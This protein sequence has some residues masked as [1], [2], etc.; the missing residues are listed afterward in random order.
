MTDPMI[1]PKTDHQP[2]QFSFEADV[3]RLLHMMVHSIYSDK[4]IFLRE[5]ISNAADACERLRHASLTAPELYSGLPRIAITA[6]PDQHRITV[7]DNGIGMSRD[8][9]MKALG[10]IA[11]SGTKAFLDTLSAANEGD[12][13]SLIGQFG[14]GFYSAFMVAAQVDVV[15]RRAGSDEAWAWTSDGKGTFSITP[16][17]IEST[18]PSG[19]KV[20]LQL[21]ENAYDYADIAT[22]KRLVRTHSAHVPVPI[23]IGTAGGE[24]EQVADGVALW[25]KPKSDLSADDYKA[26]YHG[27]GGGFDDPVATIHYRAEGR[28]DYKVLLFVPGARPFDLFDPD[29]KGRVKLYVKRVFITDDADLLPRYLRFVRG[30]VDSDDLPLNVSREMIQESPILSAIRKGVTGRVL[31]EIE[32]LAENEP[33]T[34]KTLW[35]NFGPVLKEGMYEDFERRDQLLALSRFRTTQ[36]GD[37]LASIKEILGRFR[38]NQTAFYYLVG[39]DAKRLEQSPHREGFRARGIEVLLLSDAVDGFWTTAGLSYEGKPFTS[40]TQGLADLHLIPL[41]DEAAKPATDAAPEIA[42]TLAFMK[43][44]L[45]GAVSDVRASDRLTTS[46]VCLVAPET[47]Y[48]RQ[49]EKLLKDA[50]RDIPSSQ[51]VLEVNPRHPLVERLSAGKGLEEALRADI[52]HL[53]FDEAR[54][55]DGEAP[56][57]AHAFAERL[58]RLMLRGIG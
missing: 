34:F 23:F 49:M 13:A 26:F 29:R 21:L 7:S 16:V 58:S 15:S 5:L 20:T 47:G 39:N 3:A 41:V 56:A 46:P 11:H 12:K 38:E 51:P 6:D 4:D 33:E 40:V 9:L 52:V 37:G 50:G 17:P 55:L 14:V 43:A 54:I 45:G 22:L 1:D 25:T 27:L 48:D 18:P 8:E 35:D 31:S 44:A 2:D 36:S 42:D 19:T 32:K 57:D 10:T 24:G 28:H 53:L 30:L